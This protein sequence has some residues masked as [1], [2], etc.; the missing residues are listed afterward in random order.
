MATASGTDWIK[1]LADDERRRDAL[2]LHEENRVARKADLIRLGG[3]RLIDDLR[4][5]VT[6]D[7]DTFR[8]EFEGD[9]SRDIVVDTTEATGG[10]T[11]RKPASPAVTLTAAPNLESA[12][13]TCHYRFTTLDGMPPR[14]SHFDLVFAGDGAETLQF[15]S[16]ESGRVF[17]SADALSEYLLMPVFTGRVR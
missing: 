13:V 16:P 15:K 2:R 12:T 11:V 5:T 6:R 4:A 14:E 17:A 9:R 8:R 10:F 7:V 3:R 1:Q